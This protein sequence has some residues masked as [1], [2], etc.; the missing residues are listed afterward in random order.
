MTLCACGCG[1]ETEIAK[2][3]R[4]WAGHVKGEPL[5]YLRGHNSRLAE[6]RAA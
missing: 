5:R 1:R 2:V 4:R 3:T 6:Q